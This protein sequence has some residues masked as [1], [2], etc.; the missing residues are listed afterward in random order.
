METK[1]ASAT[2]L[3][4][5]CD[6][7][8]VGGIRGNYGSR[9]RFEWAARHPLRH[10]II[11]LTALRFTASTLFVSPFRRSHV[12]LSGSRRFILAAFCRGNVV[13]CVP[14]L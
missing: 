2:L 1:A 7:A 11:T 10:P 3:V 12:H 6:V 5:G 9:L 8:H 13:Y 4:K 14:L